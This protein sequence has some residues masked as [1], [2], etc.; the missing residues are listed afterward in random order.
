ML[1]ALLRTAAVVGLVATVAAGSRP[2][3][4][5]EVEHSVIA[6]VDGVPIT[7]AE[8]S[9]YAA[10]NPEGLSAQKASGVTLLSLVNQRLVEAEAAK[11]GVSVNH[12]EVETAF[13]ALVST[14]LVGVSSRSDEGLRQLRARVRMRLLFDR[15]K[16]VVSRDVSVSQGAVEKAI[17]S[18]GEYKSLPK[19]QARRRAH[20]SLLE[21]AVEA[22]W[23]Q[24]L[25]DL[26]VCAD[27]RLTDTTYYLPVAEK[28]CG[29]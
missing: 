16:A 7:E 21:V 17:M 20:E 22:H 14:G 1:V 3:T 25:H 5:R 9:A 13:E 4:N 2:T 18:F 12:A 8:F 24:W 19:D 27:I 23:V 29:S 15:V 10:V 26:R 11:L 28:A 6:T